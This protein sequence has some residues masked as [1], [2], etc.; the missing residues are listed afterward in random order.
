M[1]MMIIFPAALIGGGLIDYIEYSPS[2][3]LP[4]LSLR[5]YIALL[6]RDIL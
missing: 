5:V 6:N 1:M 3:G 2:F 4:S